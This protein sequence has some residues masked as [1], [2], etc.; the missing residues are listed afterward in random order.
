MKRLI[1]FVA[2][3]VCLSAW[4]IEQDG[5]GNYLIGSV[6]DWDAF[7]EIVAENSTANAKMI[8][9]VNLGEDQTMIAANGYYSGT[10]DGQ[11]HTL[12]VAYNSTQPIAPFGSINNATIMNLH[13]DGTIHSSVGPLSCLAIYSYGIENISTVW[14]S[15]YVTSSIKANDWSCFGVMV[16]YANSITTHVNITDCLFSGTV[17]TY[18]KQNGFFMGYD[19]Y[20]NLATTTNCLS[21]GTFDYYSALSAYFPGTYVNTYARQFYNGSIPEDLQCTDEQIADGTIATALQAGRDEV[22]WV[23]DELN[24]SPMLTVFMTPK[25]G[26]VNRDW[27]VDINDVTALIDLLLG[28]DTSYMDSPGADANDDGNVD[29]NDVTHIIDMLLG[30]I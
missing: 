5:T 9:D 15:P 22:I 2:L 16:G 23:Q 28:V 21:V 13:I 19:G 8:A 26:D 25:L 10:F 14:A 1:L 12:T 24:G 11:G 7:A 29:I 18:G 20:N 17:A 4:A 3:M 6:A 27:R 30:V